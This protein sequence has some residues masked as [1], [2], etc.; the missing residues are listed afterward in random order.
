VKKT[1]GRQKK[2]RKA[3]EEAEKKKKEN[4]EAERRR[5]AMEDKRVGDG[6][7]YK[8]FLNYKPAEFHGENDPVI[9]TNW[10]KEI[11][12]IFEISECSPRQRMKYA[13]HLIKREVR[14]WWNMIKIAHGDDVASVMTW[15][16]FE[17]LVMENYY[18][19]EIQKSIGH[20]QYLGK[21]FLSLLGIGDGDEDEIVRT[22]RCH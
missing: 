5:K 20:F 14:H 9:V 13:S 19:L 7:S 21:K 16:E 2:P 8:S 4:E 22:L 1:L 18:L 6:C 11:E 15:E 12:D 17:D 3:T 10:L